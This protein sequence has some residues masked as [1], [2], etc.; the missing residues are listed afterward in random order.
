M[1]IDLGLIAECASSSSILPTLHG[2]SFTPDG[3]LREAIKVGQI[4]KINIGTEVRASLLRG[5][6]TALPKDLSLEVLARERFHR[7]MAAGRDA[8]VAKVREKIAI[9]GSK[10]WHERGS[11]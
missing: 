9:L 11:T 2:G 1:K 5:I 6:G 8:V 7:I 4:V 10:A 3:V